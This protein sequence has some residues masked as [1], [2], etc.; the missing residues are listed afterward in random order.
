LEFI[1]EKHLL[2]FPLICTVPWFT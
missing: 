1:Y 2:H